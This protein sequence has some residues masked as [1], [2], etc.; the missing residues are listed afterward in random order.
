MFPNLAGS[1]SGGI[2]DVLARGQP[3][4]EERT[5]SLDGNAL[6][7]TAGSII[8]DGAINCLSLEIS[9]SDGGSIFIRSPN[10]SHWIITVSDAGELVISAD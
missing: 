1:S 7:F 6:N 9:K 10:G 5:I 8:S 3:L 2:D 4:S